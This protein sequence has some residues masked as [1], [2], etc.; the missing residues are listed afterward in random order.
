MPAGTLKD[1]AIY[2][3][4]VREYAEEMELAD[5]VERA[6]RECI[7]EGCAEGLSGEA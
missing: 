6:I 2:T 5:A 7:A 3:D 1:Y 4:K